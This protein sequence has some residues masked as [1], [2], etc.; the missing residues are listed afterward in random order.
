VAA[1]EGRVRGDRRSAALGVGGGL[2]VVG[3]GKA[4]AE[5][6]GAPEP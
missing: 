4:G 5:A 2:I 3:D 6:E 1:R